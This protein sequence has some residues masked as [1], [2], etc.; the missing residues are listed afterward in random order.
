MYTLSF[1]SPPHSL[2]PPHNYGVVYGD[3][4]NKPVVSIKQMKE[5]V[6]F[7][8]EGF[9]G[10]CFFFYTPLLHYNPTAVVVSIN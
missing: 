8:T 4:S 9:L 1:F 7:I 3:I 5:S 6:E 2:K 10:G